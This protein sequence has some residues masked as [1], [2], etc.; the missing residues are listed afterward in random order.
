[1]AD[2]VVARPLRRPSARQAAVPPVEQRRRIAEIDGLRGIA[3]TLVVIFHLF[4]NGRVSGGVD[5]FLTVSGFLLTLSLARGLAAGGPLGVRRRWVRTFARLAPPAALVLAT[6][7]VLS[8][9]VLTPWTREQNLIEV[10]SAALY[11]ENW[12]LILSQLSYEAAGPATSP[13]QHFWSLSVQAQFFLVMPLVA[14]AIL[15]AIPAAVRV[16]AFWTVLGLATVLSFAYA[17][18]RNAEAPE[19]TYFDSLARFWELGVGGLAAGLFLRAAVVPARARAATGWL[20]LAM[21]VASGFVFDGGAAYPGPAAL[22]PVGGALL[23]LLSSGGGAASPSALLSSRALGGLDRLSYGLY[24][25]HWPLLIAALTVTGRDHVS[26]AG[27]AVVLA[28]AVLATVATRGL[29]RWPA[30]WANVD[31]PKRAA[32]IVAIAV[33]VAAV[34]A[35]VGI[36]LERRDGLPVELGPCAGAAALDAART[37]CADT[38]YSRVVPGLDVLREDD[39]NREECW[40][41]RGDAEFGLCTL[42]DASA[43]ARVLAVGDSHNNVLVDV[44]E[45]IARRQGWRIDVAGSEGCQWV[46]PGTVSDGNVDG[47][48]PL[49]G[50]WR[51][52]VGGLVASG[53]YDAVVTLGSSRPRFGD[54]STGIEG[55]EYHAQQLTAAWGERADP[56]VPIIAIRDNPIYG[57][58]ALTCLTDA[59]AALAGRCAVPR[60]DALIETGVERAAAS[61]PNAHVIDLT[62]RIC[63]PLSCSLAV[64]GV[65][66]TRDGSHLTGTFAST[67]APY[68][69]T[70]LL[71]LVPAPAA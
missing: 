60:A 53:D 2:P 45:D 20:G 68:L 39:A 9:T 38:V 50:Q 34:P 42:G 65:V 62:D 24:L 6:I 61:V 10:V 35:S 28:G 54:A 15:A 22:M 57:E 12:Q 26:L 52:F 5:V 4:G 7:V 11:V 18:I 27:A 1:M 70:E 71:R 21:V 64:G 49:C 33:L 66:V 55:P 3:L 31:R 30:S 56:S 17:A 41:R 25:W 29:L 51:R 36:A 43:A 59:D 13:V 32:A 46:A 8:Y 16:R 58:D 63:E 19:A 37:E 40:T 23:V 44:Y 47:G 48:Y 69:E 14:T 67:L